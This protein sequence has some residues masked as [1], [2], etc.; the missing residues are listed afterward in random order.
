M[1]ANEASAVGSLRTY[2]TAMVTYAA[3]CRAS[4]YPAGLVNI[5]P[6]AGTCAVAGIVDNVLGVAAPT[7]SGYK[8]AYKTPG[9][10]GAAAGI[11]YDVKCRPSTEVRPASQRKTE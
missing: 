3:Q 6:G 10:S 1:A 4:G 9:T 5:G 7:K 11:T 2:N 8:F